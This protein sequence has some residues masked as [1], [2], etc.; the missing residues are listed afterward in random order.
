MRVDDHLDM[1]PPLGH[2]DTA[3][4]DSIESTKPQISLLSRK[5]LH[6][7]NQTILIQNGR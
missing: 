1:A 7:A 2:V 5:L 6:S 4:T 3:C